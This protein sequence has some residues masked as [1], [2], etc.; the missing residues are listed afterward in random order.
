MFG[1]PAPASRVIL[2]QLWQ[3]QGTRGRDDHRS[4][5]EHK[6]HG[7]A[8]IFRSTRIGTTRFLESRKIG[9][10]TAHAIMQRCTPWQESPL[11]GVVNSFNEPHE[12]TRAIA[13]KPRRSKG[14]R[15]REPP[16]REYDEVDVTGSGRV[17]ERLE[18]DK[19]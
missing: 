12:L 19:D 8:E 11:F 5:L 14:T 9:A 7:A 18:N 16:G 4:R 10:V 15:H 6:C 2:L 17:T 3:R 1:E 13:M